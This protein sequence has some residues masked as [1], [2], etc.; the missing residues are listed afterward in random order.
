MREKLMNCIVECSGSLIA[1]P[2]PI[3]VSH[4]C[5]L[6]ATNLSWS[7]TGTKEVEVHAERPDGP[8]LSR[9]GPS[10]SASTG[11]WV[12]D[13]MTFFLQDV[14]DGKPLTEENTL[15]KTAVRIEA[16]NDEKS[17][18]RKSLF[19]STTWLFLQ[20]KSGHDNYPSPGK[21]SFGDFQRLNPISKKWGTDRGT[22][23]DR[24]YIENFFDNHLQDIHGHVMAVGDDTYTRMFGGQRVIKSD[25]LNLLEG[26][27]QTTIVGDLSDAP[28]ILSNTF[29]CVICTQTLQ[30]I[31]DIRSAIQTLYRILKPGGVLLATFPGISKSMDQEW[32]SYWCWSLTPLSAVKLFGEFFQEDNITIESYGNVLVAISFLHGLA[33]EELTKEELDY[34]DP[35]YEIVISVR[36][37]KQI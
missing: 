6:S 20:K 8:L 36:A 9:G 13:G 30:L 29:D 4:C 24:Y 35:G 11:K 1:T 25:V 19:Q 27:P 37:V 28:H 21:V 2:N 26:D 15:A 3:R 31:Y 18:R 17:I 12:Y 16:I 22:P 14:S 32:G 34:H 7:S 33:G 5:R 10:G 23:V